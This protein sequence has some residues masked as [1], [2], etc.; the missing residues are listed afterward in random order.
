MN[1]AI[2][3]K[4]LWHFAFAAGL[5]LAALFAGAARAQTNTRLSVS[6]DLIGDLP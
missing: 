5:T 1:R 2:S 6:C 4:I 3:K